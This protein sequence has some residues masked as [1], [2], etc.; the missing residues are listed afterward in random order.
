MKN[1]SSDLLVP[2]DVAEYLREYLQDRDIEFTVLTNN[3]EV[4]IEFG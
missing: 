4:R 2:P 3:L 1:S